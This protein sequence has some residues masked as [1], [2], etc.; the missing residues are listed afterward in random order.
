MLP[1]FCPI[2]WISVAA[3]LYSALTDCC[4]TLCSSIK[5]SFHS[6]GEVHFLPFV[7]ETS[8]LLFHLG[9]SEKRAND[10]VRHS[11]FFSSFFIRLPSLLFVCSRYVYLFALRSLPPL[12]QPL[13][14]CSLLPS[15][16]F[17]STEVL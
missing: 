4:T 5:P 3:V 17:Y 15:R 1:F 10:S 2:V 7:A 8:Q 16:C 12:K 9:S 13:M 11:L 14:E 6:N